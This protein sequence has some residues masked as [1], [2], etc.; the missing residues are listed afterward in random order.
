MMKEER[1][2]DLLQMGR[3]LW[4]NVRYIVAVTLIVGFLG[5]LGSALLMTPIYEANAK[6]IVNTRND[7]NENLTNDQLTSAK[8]LVSTYAIIITSRDVLNQVIQDLDLNMSY[9]ELKS[10]IQVQAVD[11]TQVMEVIVHHPNP[12]TALA[13]ADKILKIAPDVLVETVEAGSVKPVEQAHVGG[14]PVSPRIFRNTMIMALAGLVLS[15]VGIII[16]HLADTTYK[17]ELDIQND[18]DLPVLGVIPAI[19]SCKNQT[20]YGRSAKGRR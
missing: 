19:E 15:C 14:R 4:K 7:Q 13:V 18:L 9:T 6:M 12:K 17:S 10:S 3:V 11:A 20:S 2:I 5:L 1:E 16:V 8:N